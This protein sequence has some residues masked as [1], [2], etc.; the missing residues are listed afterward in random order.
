MVQDSITDPIFDRLQFF[1][2]LSYRVMFDI[3]GKLFSFSIG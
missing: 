2:I 3:N 1:I